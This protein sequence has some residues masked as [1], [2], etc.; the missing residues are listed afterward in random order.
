ML[1]YFNGVNSPDA[2]YI[3]KGLE[4]TF[5]NTKLRFN[6]FPPMNRLCISYFLWPVSTPYFSCAKLKLVGHYETSTLARQSIQRPYVTCRT[7]YS[8]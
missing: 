2:F 5:C 7:R 1:L 6:S 4:C 3:K 8:V